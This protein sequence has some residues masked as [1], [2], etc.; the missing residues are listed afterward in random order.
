MVR[1]VENKRRKI[2]IYSSVAVLTV[3]AVMLYLS[4]I[5]DIT[6]LPRELQKKKSKEA[7]VMANVIMWREL[8]SGEKIKLQATSVKRSTD[9]IDASGVRVTVFKKGEIEYIVLSD[10]G[11]YDLKK[12]VLYLRGN[13]KVK[14]VKEHIKMESSSLRWDTE[15][16]FIYTD[17]SVNIRKEDGTRVVGDRLKGNII[18]GRWV[19]EGDVRITIPGGGK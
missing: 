12:C 2:L 19:V 16:G 17:S 1:K 7:S 15:K 18:S 14:D 6:E 5:H 13:V 4:V 9:E 3:G 11:M 10:S 8:K